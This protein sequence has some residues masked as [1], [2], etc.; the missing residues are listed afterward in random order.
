MTISSYRA[1]PSP[2]G[3]VLPQRTTRVRYLVLAGLSAAAAIAYLQRNAVGVVGSQIQADLQISTEIMGFIKGAFFLSYALLQIPG[4]A[5]ATRYSTRGMLTL[6]ALLWSLATG[7]MG[8]AAGFWTL[9]AAQ[10]AMG[11][12]Q[13]AL[14]PCATS[15]LARWL[16]ATQRGLASGALASSMSIGAASG[17]ALAVLLF[18]QFGWRLLFFA[19][20]L[21]GLLWCIWFYWYFRDQ[22]EQHKSVGQDELAI[23]HQGQPPTLVVAAVPAAREPIPWRAIVSSWAMWCICAQHVFRAAGY[24]F[25]GSWFPDFLQ[26]TRGVS[27]RDAGLMASCPLAAVIVG[28]L[29]G[30]LVSDRL[31]KLTGSRRI[32]RQ[33]M[34]SLCMLACAALILVASQ[35]QDVRLAVAVITA[36]SFC[37]AFGGPCAY[38]ITMDMGGRHVPLVFGTMNSTGSLGAFLFP[39]VIP[40]IVIYGGG[41]QGVIYTFAGI[42]IAAG[43]AWMLFDSRGG[44]IE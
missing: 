13:A 10:L 6:Y 32:A 22:P 8:L 23:I 11:A 24:V 20:C 28:G 17:V 14:F 42:Y 26:Q 2:Q 35:V 40:F 30:G 27:L 16:P 39:T 3:T 5:L 41:W 19:Y 25:Y 21:P 36:G 18:E 9:L 37:A 33:A 4:G 12:A 44:I 1:Y 29:F 38:A 15:S 34:A 43:I 7:L 31:L